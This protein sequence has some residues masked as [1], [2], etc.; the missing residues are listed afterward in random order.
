M[1][2]RAVP[3][4]GS[5]IHIVD[6]SRGATEVAASL[7]L[8]CHASPCLA[9]PDLALPYRA[10]PSTTVPSR[11]FPYRGLESD[12]HED[13]D[14]SRGATEVATSL[15]SPRTATPHQAVP[16]TATPGHTE[17]CYALPSPANPGRE[18]DPLANEDLNRGTTEVVT[19]LALP[20]PAWPCNALPRLARPCGA[21]PR[22]ARP[23]TAVP[24]SREKPR[25]AH[26]RCAS[27]LGSGGS[28]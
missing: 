21:R 15:A 25:S 9:A 22:R 24:R 10:E 28:G 26:A 16:S 3:R 19:A 7:A 13:E 8:P 17:P 2:C 27:A 4:L 6:P 1:L 11:T 14:L 5:T 12:L 18:S 23:S 20:S